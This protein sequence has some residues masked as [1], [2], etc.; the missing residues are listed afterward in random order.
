METSLCSANSA[1]NEPFFSLSSGEIHLWSLS[2]DDPHL[3][4]KD[5]FE[6]NTSAPP[7]F[8]FDDLLA[9][10]KTLL[11]PSELNRAQARIRSEDQ[12]HF[13]LTRAA[14][15]SLLSRYLR[16]PPKK[17][18]FQTTHR[19]K[20]FLDCSSEGSPTLSF[21][22]SHSSG[23]ALLA[24]ALGHHRIGVDLEKIRPLQAR[25][26]LFQ[27]YLSP[28]EQAHLKHLPHAQQDAFFF[29]AWSAKEAL[30]KALGARI[31]EHPMAEIDPNWSD[32][33]ISPS[34]ALPDRI[35]S[36][37]LRTLPQAFGSPQN[38][39][40]FQIPLFPQFSSLLA[41]E[42]QTAQEPWRVQPY[43]WDPYCIF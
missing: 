14:L 43:F 26:A 19:G 16:I 31:L 38:W 25:N 41:C 24:L 3:R 20:P 5:H 1:E 2:W 23:K 9:Q 32:S 34:K 10:S 12:T 17:I 22:L 42:L 13:I 36:L 8:S 40:L 39:Q 29:Q 21:N 37:S 6:A 4:L 15:K 18:S 35:Q 30:I 28:R 7:R 27:R 11:N 33:S